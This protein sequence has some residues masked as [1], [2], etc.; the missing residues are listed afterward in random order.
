MVIS[1][2]KLQILPKYSKKTNC[3]ETVIKYV[4]NI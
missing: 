3:Y 1:E 2:E 4:S